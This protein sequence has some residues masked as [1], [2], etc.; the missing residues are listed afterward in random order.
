MDIRTLLGVVVIV[1]ACC[2]L[3]LW[4][5]GWHVRGLRGLRWFQ[6]AY[7]STALGLGCADWG[8]DNHI[9]T[10]VAG[11]CLVM[12][13]AVLMSQG[14]AEFV[15][16]Q[17]NLLAWG[18]AFWL[19]FCALEIPA[20]LTGHSD[21]GVVL[22]CTFFAAQLYIAALILHARPTP[23][24]KSIIRSAAVFI[25]GMASVCLLRAAVVPFRS[26]PADPFVPD[27]LRFG[28]LTVFMVFSAAMAFGFIGVVTV[29]LRG[30]ME[31]QANTDALTGVLN[32]RAI[33]RLA[34][35]EIAACRARGA[36]LAVVAVDL[37]RFK[38]V[39]DVYGHAAGDAVLCAT[40]Q[41]LVQGVRQTDQ[42]ARVGGEEFVLVLPTRGPQE[43]FEVAERLRLKL[44]GLEIRHGDAALTMTASFGVAALSG[45]S[46]NW[47][48]LFRRAD[49]W[50]YLA[51]QEGRN[52]TRGDGDFLPAAPAVAT[53]QPW[54][55][56]PRLAPG[57]R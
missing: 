23:D 15:S 3:G 46:D 36:T 35:G 18:G 5:I 20:A 39:N 50:L 29:R 32:R 1:Q 13:A 33:E 16:S 26:L 27:P 11:R 10:Q 44:Q 56:P 37:D 8:A 19:L 21:A 12:L 48:Q 41:A 30:Q 6:W 31:M 40:A 54:P 22:F 57:T 45:F 14:V 38:A 25:A 34:P 24:E 4:A 53:T 9:W 17:A 2:A 43:A 28:G 47:S 49:R 42:V 7:A 51:K 55:A 52:R